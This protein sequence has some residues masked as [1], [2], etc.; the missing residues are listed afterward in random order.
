MKLLEPSDL[1]KDEI[2]A[3]YSEVKFITRVVQAARTLVHAAEPSKRVVNCGEPGGY[4]SLE[5]IRTRLWRPMQEG[6]VM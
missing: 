6:H 4:Q 5:W 1:F 2:H 3:R